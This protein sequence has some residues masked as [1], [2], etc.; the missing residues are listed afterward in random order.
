MKRA[1]ALVLIA[2]PLVAATSATRDST[3]VPWGGGRG[4]QQPIAFSHQIHAGKLAMNCLYCHYSA[5]KSPIANIPPVS[6]CMGCHKL[7]MTDRPE[8]K[9]LSSY[10]ERG[11]VVPWVE[12]YRLPDHVKFNHKRHVKA[13][14]QCDECHGKVETMTVLYQFPSLRMGW[15]ITCHRQKLNDPNFPATLD[16]VACHH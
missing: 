7:A 4:P 11:E 2:M 10:W 15:C 16:C 8:I 1:L 9:K 12:V 5:D 13:G 6:V 3:L 14:F